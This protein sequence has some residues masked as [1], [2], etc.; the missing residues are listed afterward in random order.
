MEEEGEL[1]ES[2]EIEEQIENVSDVA[3]DDNP[4]GLDLVEDEEGDDEKETRINR[5]FQS[6]ALQLAN[7]EAKKLIDEFVN[8]EMS[9]EKMTLVR[10]FVNGLLERLNFSTTVQEIEDEIESLKSFALDHHLKLNVREKTVNFLLTDRPKDLV[11]KIPYYRTLLSLLIIL[12]PKIEDSQ[13][14]RFIESIDKISSNDIK[15][16]ATIE[17]EVE[18]YLQSYNLP[19]DGKEVAEMLKENSQPF[20]GDR[21][22]NFVIN[23]PFV[24]IAGGYVVKNNDFKTRNHDEVKKFILEQGISVEKEKEIK[25]NSTNYADYFSKIADL[26]NPDAKVEDKKQSID[27]ILK[28]RERILDK[29]PKDTKLKKEKVIGKRLQSLVEKRIELDKGKSKIDYEKKYSIID[30]VCYYKEE[31]LKKLKSI[32]NEKLVR[33]SKDRMIRF[34]DLGS[35]GI[36]VLP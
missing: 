17:K 29:A 36:R 24:G 20:T 11:D 34:L 14:T 30:G 13:L 26:F 16:M 18:E 27:E 32:A 10:D 3:E 33:P 25:E 35:S 12:G 21:G 28:E 22:D 6:D 19:T 15:S 7:V 8:Q 1:S 23:Q 31:E 2:E 9:K 5:E 4:E